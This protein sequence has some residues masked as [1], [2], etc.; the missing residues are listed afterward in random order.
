M[1]PDPADTEKNIA[2]TREFN[3]AMKPWSTGRAYLNF[4]GD[5]GAARVEA[6]FGPEKFARLQALKDEVGP[7]EP[8]PHQP[9]HP[10]ERV[11]DVASRH[12]R[13]G[14]C[15]RL[16]RRRRIRRAHGRA[17]AAPAA[18]S[19]SSCSRRA[20]A[21]AAGS[22][23]S[24]LADG[25]AVDRGG[26]WLGP[27]ARRDLRRSRRGGRVDVQDVGEGRAPP[28]RRASAPAATRASSRRSAR[29][30]SSRSR[31]RS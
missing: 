21:S 16:R 19:R 1:W 20:T 30:R 14:R 18:G 28:R 25:T 5:E 9:E 24:T 2:Y 12:A 4:L 10:A 22:G 6:A 31:W 3:G 11:R 7:A 26:A 8:V 29:S 17:A 27:A 15:G 23:P 13:A